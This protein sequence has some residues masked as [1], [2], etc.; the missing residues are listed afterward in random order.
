MRILKLKRQNLF[1]FLQAISNGAEL[2][3]P[4]KK[5]NQTIFNFVPTEEIAK[6]N[7]NFTRTLLP[8]K[9]L[10]VPPSF[11]MFQVTNKGYQEDYSWIKE[12]VLFGL[13]PC[14][15]H[16][17]LNLDRIFAQN[18]PDS[19]YVQARQ[20]TLL[21]GLS[22]WPDDYCL[23]QSTHTDIIEE[24]FDLFFT[25]LEDY[26]LVWIGSSKGDDLIRLKPEFFEEGLNEK[27]IESYIKWRE[28]RAQ[29]FKTKI[30]FV[31]MPDLMELKYN[32][33]LWEKAGAACL[34]CGSCS[35]VCPTCNCY[36]VRDEISLG[37]KPGRR[38]REWDS[39][40]L[41]EYS[42]VAGGENFR[43]KKSSRLKLWYTHK[44]QAF[45]SKFGKPSCVGCG[46]C[47]V[48]CPVGINVKSIS[49]SLEGQKVDAFWVRFS[50]EVR[51]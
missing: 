37:N 23:C 32:S 38:V 3:G 21:L 20:K 27:D 51:P 46:R 14:D 22:C 28:R 36:N 35:M 10:F 25:D 16:G 1:P 29:A 42:L 17:L 8:P 7:L 43:E 15:L 44:L 5:D 49:D 18:F 2:W 6:L 31:F 26:Y 34:A 47:L 40:T 4:I 50:E 12:R 48:T 33:P 30:N 9:K 24:G 11:I 41:L 39:C 19:Y 45:G 13:H